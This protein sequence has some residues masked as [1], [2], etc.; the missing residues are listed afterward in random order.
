MNN[1]PALLRVATQSKSHLLK[2]FHIT[3]EANSQTRAQQRTKRQRSKEQDGRND[4]WKFTKISPEYETKNLPDQTQHCSGSPI[5]VVNERHKIKWQY[6][7]NQNEYAYLNSSHQLLRWKN[8]NLSNA[9][10]DF[11]S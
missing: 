2:P 9:L 4:W 1:L 11:F 8:W 10:F 5:E 7:I 3:V 6:Q